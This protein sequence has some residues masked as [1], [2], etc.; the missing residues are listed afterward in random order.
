MKLCILLLYKYNL[1]ID[2][3]EKGTGSTLELWR[4]RG[5]VSDAIMTSITLYF[6]LSAFISLSKQSE[7]HAWTKTIHFILGL[8]VF[9]FY[10]F[11]HLS[12]K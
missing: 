9:K 3:T 4:T 10:V 12:Q 6:D 7:K 8:T 5:N 1:C 2:L 11:T